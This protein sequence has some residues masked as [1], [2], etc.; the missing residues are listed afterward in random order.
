MVFS[1][2]GRSDLAATSYQDD[3]WPLEASM[4]YAC[5]CHQPRRRRMVG[6]LVAALALPAASVPSLA[7]PTPAAIDP[8]LACKDYGDISAATRFVSAEQVEAGAQQ[9][10]LQLLQKA[11]SQRALGPSDHAQVVRLRAIAE[12]IIPFASQC[13]PRA[14][15]WRWE[16]NLLGSSQVN[17][18]CM[19]GGKIAFFHGI[20]ATLQLNDDEVAAIMGHEVAHALREHAREQIGKSMATRW[21]ASIAGALLGLGSAGDLVAQVSAQL[22]S[23]KFGR[24]DEAEADIVGM[25]LA[26]RAGYDPAAGVTLWQKMGAL[27]KGSPPAWLSTHPAGNT[28]IKDIQGKL[29]RM[30]PL[31]DNAAKPTQRFAPPPASKAA[32]ARATPRQGG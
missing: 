26:A 12:R 32:G 23:L 2:V 11:Q 22:L 28:R 15:Q 9:Q 17:A 27:N 20:L 3:A 16:V 4:P 29:P 10:Y 8:N 31:F 24:S 30:K 1:S 7:A 6:G 14:K 19:P 13:N 25:E 18:F 21:G 5:P